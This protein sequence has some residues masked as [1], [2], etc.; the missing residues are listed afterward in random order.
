MIE[1][2]L[3]GPLLT[4]APSELL[5]QLLRRG[6]SRAVWEE[7]EKWLIELRDQVDT[8]NPLYTVQLLCA[9]LHQ[10]N[11]TRKRVG[12][13][14]PP[15]LSYCT[16]LVWTT[17]AVLCLHST[18]RTRFLMSTRGPA[19]ILAL[20]KKA[21]QRSHDLRPNE[22]PFSELLNGCLVVFNVATSCSESVRQPEKQDLFTF[23]P[24]LVAF[25]A[26]RI[27]HDESPDAV[28]AFRNILCWKEGIPENFELAISAALSETK[29]AFWQ[30]LVNDEHNDE[31]TIFSAVY[32]LWETFQRDPDKPLLSQ[33]HEE[34]L[35]RRL[36][37]HTSVEVHQAIFEILQY[38]W[39]QSTRQED[40][41]QVWKI[42]CLCNVLELHPDDESIMGGCLTLLESVFR[43]VPNTKLPTDLV[44]RIVRLA[45]K[46]VKQLNASKTNWMA[47]QLIF[48]GLEEATTNLSGL[49][50]AA[51]GVLSD[52]F[53]TLALLP[54]QYFQQQYFPSKFLD[55]AVASM[56]SVTPSLSLLS[57]QF[58]ARMSESNPALAT[59]LCKLPRFF[60][61]IIEYLRDD[62]LRPEILQWVG[63]ILNSS[64]EAS[65]L[66]ELKVTVNRGGIEI[67][68]I[69]IDRR[70]ED[71]EIII[72]AIR[73]FARL[74]PLVTDKLFFQRNY[75]TALLSRALHESIYR[76]LDKSLV[77]LD[78][79]Y[80]LCST[81]D[82][83]KD[84]FLKFLSILL[85]C[86]KRYV[87]CLAIQKISCR[88]LRMLCEFDA[89]ATA[90]GVI[91]VLIAS[92][93]EHC[94]QAAI[95]REGL[96]IVV[97][98]CEEFPALAERVEEQMLYLASFHPGDLAMRNTIQRVVQRERTF[99]KRC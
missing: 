90:R 58:L 52:R 78:A 92:M 72:S 21:H 40:S 24:E 1:T 38:A 51:D 74:F 47:S 16:Q 23:L 91:P 43:A 94:Q 95:I 39:M 3:E 25:L 7:A 48:H 98:F 20:S 13:K 10:V 19:A 93:L 60:P 2:E 49:C 4:A 27:K 77:L 15:S 61:V 99:V 29:D 41:K 9:L 62:Q 14:V 84:E 44:T 6:T 83:F 59:R 37:K 65:S 45:L 87:A 46:R 57:V 56:A 81:R 32:L 35:F 36:S 73:N 31:A 71:D 17:V 50:K 96:D 76:S 80:L 89:R 8:L 82:F 33:G 68:L 70:G 28:C 34:T 18:T 42:I 12:G 30:I 63:I 66:V 22:L 5:E 79:W 11:P 86:M 54:A 88:I 53:E 64:I 75:V 26:L 67:L 69:L 85:S 97:L 55:L